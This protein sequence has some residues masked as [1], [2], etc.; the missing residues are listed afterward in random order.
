MTW[1]ILITDGMAHEGMDIMRA[2]AEVIESKALEALNTMD[3]LI[4]RSRT[5][6]TAQALLAGAPRLKVIGRAGIGVD[7]IDLEAARTQGVVVVN[8]PQAATI[9]VAEHTLA[10]MFA[11]ARHT[12]R[13]DASMRR[14][15]WI[16]AKLRCTEVHG[17]ILGIIGMGHIGAATAQRA[18]ALGL[19][20]LGFDPFL[21]EDEIRDR[22]A[23]PT[24]MDELLS[25][26]D[27]ISVHVPLTEETHGLIDAQAFAR[28]K[29]SARLINT[30]RGGIVDETALLAA[31]D[32]GHVAGAALDVFAH[33]PP[34][35][36]PLV[37]HPRVISTPHISAQTNEAQARVS[38][39]IA[40]E[41]LAAL[42]GE[43]L[44][45]RVA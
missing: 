44:R 37:E 22:G 6:V 1:R 9:S 32:E 38:T 27:Y 16:K 20:V 5:Q 26:A 19:R 14:G 8:T 4:V 24:T 43:P 42:Q 2:E 33:E 30:S 28:V 21:S 3:A 10:L 35:L 25:H 7:N 40:T 23:D 18:T 11:L 39:D 17:K 13:A 31:L 36:T 12:P 41:V 45:W 29:P 15:E 34:G